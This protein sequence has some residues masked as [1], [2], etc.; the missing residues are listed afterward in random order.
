M[1]LQDK[2]KTRVKPKLP[3]RKFTFGCHAMIVDFAN[4]SETD[5]DDLDP[6][7]LEIGGKQAR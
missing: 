4:L 2:S 7:A 3:H 6:E 1:A 5:F